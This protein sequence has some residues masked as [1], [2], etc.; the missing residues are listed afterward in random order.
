ME[1]VIAEQ[2]TTLPAPSQPQGMSSTLGPRVAADYEALRNDL[3]QAQAIASDFQ[4]EAAGKSNELAEMRMF[5]ERT[6]NDLTKLQ[7]SI[8]QLRQERH[9]LANRVMIASA[10]EMRLK[11]S[12][13]ECERLRKE[14]D[15]FRGAVGMAGTEAKA[16]VRRL[17]IENARL[18][19]Q[20]ESLT[21]RGAGAAPGTGSSD[22]TSQVML[23]RILATVEGL[24]ESIEHLPRNGNP[25][26]LDV[27]FDS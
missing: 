16:E 24:R 4:R 14:A 7:T 3:E 22:Q 23:A 25:G 11:R 20:I 18:L 1:T 5:L 2:E 8:A 13:A 15:A 12:E 19:T 9:D 6:Q 21:L 26:F 27:S 10:A 17:E